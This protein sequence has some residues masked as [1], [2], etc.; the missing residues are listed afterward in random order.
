M[1]AFIDRCLMS[2]DVVF[3]FELSLTVTALIFS[4]LSKIDRL[5]SRPNARRGVLEKWIRHTALL[6]RSQVSSIPELRTVVRSS[7]FRRNLSDTG[8]RAI[9]DECLSAKRR[10]RELKNYGEEAIRFIHI[11]CL[12]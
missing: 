2:L 6:I 9:E 8:K 3:V 11:P 10:Q 7:R 1:T 4:L 5:I 12:F